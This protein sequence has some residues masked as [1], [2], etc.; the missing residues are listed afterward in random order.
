MFNSLTLFIMRCK[1][2]KFRVC[3]MIVSHPSKKIPGDVSAT[4]KMTP[5][6]TDTE[7]KRLARY[8]RNDIGFLLIPRFEFYRM[9][10]FC[11]WFCVSVYGPCDGACRNK[12]LAFPREKKDTPTRLTA[13]HTPIII[14]TWIPGLRSRRDYHYGQ[15]KSIGNKCRLCVYKWRRELMIGWYIYIFVSD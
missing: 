3:K 13:R 15:L 12:N 9:I 8:N 5:V 7:E 4:P 6:R 2:R 1:Y 14:F 10:L 11:F